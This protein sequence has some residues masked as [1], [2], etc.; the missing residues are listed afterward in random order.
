MTALMELPYEYT[1]DRRAYET[2]EHMEEKNL[3][4]LKTGLS[5]EHMAALGRCQ[6]ACQERHAMELEAM[7]LAAFSIAREL[8]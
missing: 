5:S 7:F 8:L 2:A 6:D 4:A 3:A 1:Q